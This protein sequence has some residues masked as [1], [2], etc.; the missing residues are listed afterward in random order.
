MSGKAFENH[1]KTM[2]N[3]QLTLT[4]HGFFMVKSWIVNG[5]YVAIWQCSY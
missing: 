2:E 3:D 4:V 1:G 5:I